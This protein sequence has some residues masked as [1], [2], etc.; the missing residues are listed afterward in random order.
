MHACIHACMH[1]Y[2]HTHT[3]T[4]GYREGNESAVG[5]TQRYFA[6]GFASPDKWL[7]IGESN[8]LNTSVEVL[9]EQANLLV[10]L[11]LRRFQRFH[12]SVHICT[13]ILLSVPLLSVLLL[14]VL[15]LSVLLMSLLL[16]SFQRFHLRVHT[17]V[18]L[19]IS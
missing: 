16:R 17:C 19:Y 12:L 7:P 9:L 11:S 4:H 18:C 15:L 2:I 3:H 10:R 13:L 8:L 6:L 5:L 1:A 14:S